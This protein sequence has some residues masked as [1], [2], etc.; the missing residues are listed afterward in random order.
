[1]IVENV[2]QFEIGKRKHFPLANCETNLNDNTIIMKAISY[3][4]QSS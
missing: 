4:T 2:H 1:M 3:S